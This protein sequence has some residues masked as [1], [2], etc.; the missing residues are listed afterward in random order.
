MQPSFEVIHLGMLL[1]S[2]SRSIVETYM[3]SSVIP[4]NS[5]WLNIHYYGIKLCKMYRLLN[6]KERPQNACNDR[7]WC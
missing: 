1:K 7:M 3:D 4:S 6:L 5:I 2:L